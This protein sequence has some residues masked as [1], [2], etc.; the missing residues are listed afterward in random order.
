VI[1]LASSLPTCFTDPVSLRLLPS[2]VWNLNKVEKVKK[3]EKVEKV[4]KS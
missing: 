2:S 3:V 1:S 4:I